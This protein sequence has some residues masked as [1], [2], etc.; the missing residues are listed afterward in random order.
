M[1]SVDRHIAIQSGWI[2]G[3]AFGVAMMAAPEYLHLGPLASAALFWGGIAVFLATI[4]VVVVVS[5]HEEGK[6]KAV[7]GPVIIMAIGALIFCGGAAW[8][9]WPQTAPKVVETSQP[10]PPAPIP[11]QKP[12]SAGTEP[13]PAPQPS[14]VRRYAMEGLI[15]ARGDLLGIKKESLSCDALSAWQS[16]ADAATRLAHA[17]GIG[18]HNP[19][20]QYLGAC[21]NITDVELLDAIR[22]DIIRLLDQGI[23]S[24]GG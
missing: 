17:N 15:K 21:R 1:M 19:I 14:G 16:R 11:P 10:P 23:R 24:A 9:F 6:R 13:K 22:A 12:E 7:I 20:S 8:Y 3:P 5:L 2:A 18:V 4:A